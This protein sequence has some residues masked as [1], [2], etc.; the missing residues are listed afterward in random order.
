MNPSGLCG[1]WIPHP[2]LGFGSF[3]T[4]GGSSCQRHVFGSMTRPQT[5]HMSRWARSCVSGAS[6][7]AAVNGR[8]VYRTQHF[9]QTGCHTRTGP[10]TSPARALNRP[11]GPVKM[12]PTLEPEPEPHGR[13]PLQPNSEPGGL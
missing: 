9:G 11:G 3:A 7:W 12:V 8:L 4:Q 13:F 10:F 5:H 2:N 1:P 6:R